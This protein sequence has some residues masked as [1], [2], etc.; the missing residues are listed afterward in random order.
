MS[1]AVAKTTYHYIG[2]NLLAAYCKL[3]C[4]QGSVEADFEVGHN[5]NVERYEVPD[6]L[7]ACYTERNSSELRRQDLC[8]K[9]LDG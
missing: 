8:A 2:H 6:D 1:W 5:D 7:A 3:A 4:M 9:A